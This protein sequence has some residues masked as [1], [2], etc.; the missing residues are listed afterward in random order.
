MVDLSTNSSHCAIFF[1]SFTLY[2]NFQDL[3]KYTREQKKKVA[4][5]EGVGF[6]DEIDDFQEPILSS[7]S[8][9]VR[10]HYN[11]SPLIHANLYI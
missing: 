10:L 6:D 5:G 4:R 1:F 3:H 9:L 7:L 8:K 11:I 2:E